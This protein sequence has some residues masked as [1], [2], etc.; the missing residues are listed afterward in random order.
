MDRALSLEVGKLG[1]APGYVILKWSL[2]GL[3][4][5]SRD[6]ELAQKMQA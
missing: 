2:L 5:L 3:K 6:G 4:G 1:K